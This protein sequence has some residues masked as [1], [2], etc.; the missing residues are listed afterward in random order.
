M[1]QLFGINYHVLTI[2][3]MFFNYFIYN[4]GKINIDLLNENLWIRLL[5]YAISIHINVHH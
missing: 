5:F 3:L 2:K 4:N 1:I